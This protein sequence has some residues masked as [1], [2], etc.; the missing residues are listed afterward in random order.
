MNEPAEHRVRLHGKPGA[1]PWQKRSRW[2]P[3]IDAG[4]ALVM[5]SVL[6]V[7]LLG[8]CL[9]GVVATSHRV[10]GFNARTLWIVATPAGHQLIDASDTDQPLSDEDLLGSLF[11]G[12]PIQKR[13]YFGPATVVE[14]RVPFASFSVIDGVSLTQEQVEKML[15][16]AA[17]TT[18]FLRSTKLSRIIQHS[19]TSFECEF[20]PG[21]PKILWS[22]IAA[23]FGLWC[24]L[25]LVC[26][27]I[28]WFVRSFIQFF[29]PRR[30]RARK[31]GEHLCP[32]CNYDVRL[33]ESPR[34]PE[35]GERLTI[36]PERVGPAIS[37]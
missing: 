26:W 17:E 33:I 36:E 20:T 5:S 13:G 22:G 10:R 12:S 28:A 30:K 9:M 16:T 14:R 6:L 31:L 25:A 15:T 4:D 23:N 8:G 24:Y 34:C 1:P 21:P 2:F 19:P 3:H 27:T 35:C 11:C 18:S 29:D 32:R 7:V 37:E